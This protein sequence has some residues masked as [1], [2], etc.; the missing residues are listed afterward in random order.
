MAASVLAVAA[1]LY[2]GLV[3]VARSRIEKGDQSAFFAPRADENRPLVVAH[4]G[5]ELLRPSNTMVAFRHAVELGADVIDTDLHRTADGVLVLLHDETVDRTSDGTGAVRDLTLAELQGLDFGHDFTLDDGATYPYRGQG[6]GIVTVEELFAAFDDG[7]RFGIEIKQTGPEAATELCALIRAASYEDRVLVSSFAQ[8]NM[9]VF[10]SACPD[11]ATSATEAEVRTFY[12]LHRAGLNGLA[13]PRYEALQVPER[14]AG[15]LLLS[16]GFVASAH[17][18]GVAV[19]PWT[20]DDPDDLDRMIGLG[21]DGINTNV[22][23]RLLDR[24]D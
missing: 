21:V 3:G 11:V 6:H 7:T 4:Q 10:R 17:A 12:L 8:P 2:G 18:W 9:D 13:T 5:G 14:A 24:L 16:E 22:P 20:I 23:D 1:L 15:L 19:V